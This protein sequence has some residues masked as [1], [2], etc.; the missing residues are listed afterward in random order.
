[1]PRVGRVHVGEFPVGL[2]QRHQFRLL[3]EDGLDPLLA[4][5]QPQQHGPHLAALCVDGQRDDAD[6]GQRQ[7]I[8]ARAQRRVQR[9]DVGI[10]GQ[11]Q[12]EVLDGRK[13]RDNVNAAQVLGEQHTAFTEHGTDDGQGRLAH[14][15]EHGQFEVRASEARRGADGLVLVAAADRGVGGVVRRPD[16]A[17][18]AVEERKALLGDRPADP[19]SATQDIVLGY[20]QVPAVPRQVRGLADVV[21]RVHHLGLAAN[22]R[23]RAA[24]QRTIGVVEL[25]PGQ[26][27][28]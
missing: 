18:E 13:R 4:L 27:G 8:H 16:F 23:A 15:V 5:D 17:E 26:L 10:D 3:F 11:P 25:D 21:Q 19:L 28:C 22:H 6:D 7:R 1:M 2:G 20:E 9:L 12:A 24:N 14:G